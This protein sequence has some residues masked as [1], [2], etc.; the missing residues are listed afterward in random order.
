MRTVTDAHRSL[1]RYLALALGP[2]WEVRLSEEKGAFRR[3]FARISL[4]PSLAAE[5]IGWRYS[6]LTGAWQIAAFPVRGAS[7]DE[8]QMSALVVHDLLVVAFAGQG[9]DPGSW[10]F[11]LDPTRGIPHRIPLFDYSQAAIRGAG[12]AVTQADRAPSDFMRVE[13]V[14]EVQVIQSEADERLFSLA[15]NI[16][17]SWTRSA[18]IPSSASTTKSFNVEADE[19]NG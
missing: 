16:R 11:A 1:K 9:F 15:A 19:Q 4:V 18:A 10:P 5:T 2:G 6:K 7:P 8:A 14:P 3:P 17:M 12:A 13:G